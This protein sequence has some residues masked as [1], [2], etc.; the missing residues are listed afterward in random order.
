MAIRKPDCQ[1]PNKPYFSRRGG[2]LDNGVFHVPQQQ[3]G[4]VGWGVWGGG[5][6][7]SVFHVLLNNRGVERTCFSTTVRCGWGGGGGG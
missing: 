2:G 7:N 3:R 6:D 5:L 4:V 1:L